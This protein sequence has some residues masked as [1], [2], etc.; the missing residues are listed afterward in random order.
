MADGCDWRLWLARHGPPLLLLARQRVPNVSD[1]EDIVQEAFLRFWHSRHRANDP[2]AYLYACTRR[3]CDEWLRDRRR[4]LRREQS[5]AC[6]EWTVGADLFDAAEFAERR[7]LIEAA[8]RSLPA[9]QREVVIMKL[10]GDLSFGQIAA[11]VSIPANTAASRYRY[12]ME[13]LREQ[14]TREPAR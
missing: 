12:A 13:K 10:W 9:E 7:L 3:R 6:R 4:R 11:A 1:A 2:V 8:L 14:L 5:A